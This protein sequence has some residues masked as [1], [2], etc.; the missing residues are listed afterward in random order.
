[1][2]LHRLF[3]HPFGVD[4]RGH[5]AF[6]LGLRDSSGDLRFFQVLLADLASAVSAVSG[7]NCRLRGVEIDQILLDK[8]LLPQAQRMWS[9]CVVVDCATSEEPQKI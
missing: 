8:A 7:A 2:Q 6:S 4:L 9:T 3:K 5:G 1:M